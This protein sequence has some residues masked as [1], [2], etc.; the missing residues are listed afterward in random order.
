MKYDS[1]GL[2]LGLGLAGAYATWSHVF[3]QNHK[4]EMAAREEQ[5]GTCT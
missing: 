1:I 5:K 4:D 2:R 3:F